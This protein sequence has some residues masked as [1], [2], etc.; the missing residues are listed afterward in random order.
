ML[1]A[2]SIYN[3]A[4]AAVVVPPP[5]PPFFP[6]PFP[7][8][9]FAE[10][11]RGC[12]RYT[13]PPFKRGPL[14]YQNPPEKAL[15]IRA[16]RGCGGMRPAS[17]TGGSS[18]CQRCSVSVERTSHDRLQ[19]SGRSRRSSRTLEFGSINRQLVVVTAGSAS[20][21]ATAAAV[22]PELHSR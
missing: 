1:P 19:P 3:L 4:R 21:A 7:R 20:A 6:L 9:S 11:T 5:S 22:G 10:R 2:C 15:S 16:C 8:P 17:Y 14:G 13:S 18:G 12:A